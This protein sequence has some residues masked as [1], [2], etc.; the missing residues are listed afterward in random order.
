MSRQALATCRSCTKAQAS[1][2]A[3]DLWHRRRM[4]EVHAALRGSLEGRGQAVDRAEWDGDGLWVAPRRVG[5]QAG[6]QRP[7]Q[8]AAVSNK[9]LSW[10][11]FHRTGSWWSMA[12]GWRLQVPGETAGSGA[13]V[14]SSVERR[15][16]SV[17]RQSF[18]EAWRRALEA[19]AAGAGRTLGRAFV[20]ASSRWPTKVRSSPTTRQTRR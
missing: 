17:K 10:S 9:H 2:P 14:G 20:A 6:Q 18:R 19:E 13:R 5:D 16:S 8:A 4:E 7:A 11:A 15:A 1:R 12:M 3:G